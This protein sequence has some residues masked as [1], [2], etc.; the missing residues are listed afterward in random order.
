MKDKL[1]RRLDS[2]CHHSHHCLGNSNKTSFSHAVSVRNQ[3][4]SDLHRLVSEEAHFRELTFHRITREFFKNSATNR[5]ASED[6][7]QPISHF[8][9]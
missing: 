8:G 1:L 4:A 5:N 2:R 7:V 3:N 9:F 6:V